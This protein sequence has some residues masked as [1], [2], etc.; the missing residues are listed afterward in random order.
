MRQVKVL[1]KNKETGILTQHDDGSFTFRYNDNWIADSTKK[2]ISLSLPKTKK[3]HNSRILFPFF[4]NMLPEGTNKQLV[5][6][7]NRIDKD[8]AFGLLI[9]TAKEDNIGAVVIQKI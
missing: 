4:Y 7:Q 8:D 9:I 6:T 5:C 3:E 1:F 2:A